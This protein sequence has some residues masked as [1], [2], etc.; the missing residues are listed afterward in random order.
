M[1]AATPWYESVTAWTAI[2]SVAVTLTLL[3]AIVTTVRAYVYARRSLVYALTA[4]PLISIAPGG[5][6]ELKILHGD[7]ELHDPYILDIRLSSKARRDIPSTSFDQGKPLCIDVGVPVVAVNSVECV[8]ESA[9]IP[10]VE[11]GETCVKI[12]PSLIRKRQTVTLAILVDGPGAQLKFESALIEVRLRPEVQYQTRGLHLKQILSWAAI[13]F[14]AFYLVT[15]PA[16]AG[17]FVHSILNGLKSAGNSL[18]SF[19]N[20][21]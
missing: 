5:S 6:S 19:F 13:A 9:P 20:S 1:S 7:K 10:K 3:F 14:V 15:Q 18:A 4:F 21:L 12:G 17:H 8:P 11:V 16:A 2:G